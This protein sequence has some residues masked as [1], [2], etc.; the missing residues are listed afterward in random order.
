MK[1]TLIKKYW[2][3]SI[4]IRLGVLAI[5]ILGLWFLLGKCNVPS[6][7]FV[8]KLD[9]LNRVNDSLL[10]Q[11]KKADSLIT[12]LVAEDIKLTD[13]L[14]EEKSKVKVIHD[15]VIKEVEIVK[16]ADSLAIV[17]FFNN[18]YPAQTILSDTL[19]PLNKP[20][21]I[22][23]A[24]D[25]VK[26]DGA[27]KEIAVKDSM[28]ALQD[29]RINLKD[30]TISLFKTKESNLQTVITNKDVAI[31]EWTKQYK[32]LQIQ[33]K[34]LKLQSKFQKIG[35]FLLAGGLVYVITK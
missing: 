5:I 25:L 20:V 26:Y 17:K 18:R 28:I 35:T 9:S 3:P 14:E 19:I 29:I 23:A 31:E 24:A 2:Y 32:S 12:E 13:L 11:N 4:F 30:S 7:K 1:N 6:T 27:V 33:N 10:L 15:I 16:A 21:L 34:K 8:E 22:E